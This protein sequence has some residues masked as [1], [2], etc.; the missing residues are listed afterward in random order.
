MT[1][2]PSPHWSP[3]PWRSM[4]LVQMMHSVA[5]LE[6]VLP[7]LLLLQPMGL[8]SATV[9]LHQRFAVAACT[10]ARVAVAVAV[11]VAPKE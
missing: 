11:A 5:L 4:L 1:S 8:V 3:H 6:I 9:V 10:G 2:S 7:L